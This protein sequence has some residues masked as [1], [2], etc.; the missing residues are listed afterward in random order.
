MLSVGIAVEEEGKGKGVHYR[1]PVF[2][3]GR[4]LLEESSVVQ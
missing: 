3:L 2:D 1:T 4:I